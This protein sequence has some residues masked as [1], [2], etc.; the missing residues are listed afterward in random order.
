MVRAAP[1]LPRCLICSLR[2]LDLSLEPAAFVASGERKSVFTICSCSAAARKISVLVYSETVTPILRAVPST[3]FMA[4][5]MSL[6]L[7]SGNLVVA[8]SRT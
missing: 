7:R 6:A 2:S 1:A 3:I 5:S 8:M 4:D